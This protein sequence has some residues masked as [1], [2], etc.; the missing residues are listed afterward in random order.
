[1][2]GQ[3]VHLPARGA[4]GSAVGKN[5]GERH[6]NG[7]QTHRHDIV[8]E[9]VHHECRQY[10]SAAGGAKASHHRGFEDADASRCVACDTERDCPDINDE[11]GRKA[12]REIGWQKDVEHR[13]GGGHVDDADQRLRQCD[14][15]PRQ[16]QRDRTEGKRPRL[17]TEPDQYCGDR[18]QDH[19]TGRGAQGQR[20]EAENAHAILMQEQHDRQHD[21][22][23]DPEENPDTGNDGGDQRQIELVAGI[24]ARTYGRSR[25]VGK[26]QQV[27]DRITGCAGKYRHA[28]RH[29]PR[30]NRAQSKHIVERK[31]EIADRCK[32]KR[33]TDRGPGQRRN[34]RLHLGPG[35]FRG[36]PM[37]HEKRAQ[38]DDESDG[39]EHEAPGFT[40]EIRDHEGSDPRQ[41]TASVCC[42][43][44]N[45]PED[46][47]SDL[48]GLLS[49][50]RRTAP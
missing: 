49:G 24:D 2:T 9:A 44:V 6:G 34:V 37:E 22:D 30:R 13:G 17:S 14:P 39:G 43:L 19:G 12:G 21:G 27:G 40:P 10:I 31:G 7:G 4:H 18:N 28:G 3:P 20:N 50:K 41:F 47:E 25:D 32:E 5:P 42:M 8:D 33:Q 29:A 23:T 35:D 26:S 46:V 15:R 36:N 1:M 45:S 11:I 48:P 38:K 16:R